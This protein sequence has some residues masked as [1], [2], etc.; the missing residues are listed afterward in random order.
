LDCQFTLVLIVAANR[1]AVCCCVIFQSNTSTPPVN[2]WC[3]GRESQF[4]LT[5]RKQQ[6]ILGEIDQGNCKY[7]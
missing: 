5:N 3:M 6:I 7:F 2:S 4:F 1:D